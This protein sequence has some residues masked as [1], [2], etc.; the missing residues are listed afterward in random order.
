[1]PFQDLLALKILMSTGVLDSENFLYP[2][3][4]SRPGSSVQGHH[5]GM[6]PGTF[7][8]LTGASGHIM[9]LLNFWQVGDTL[10][11]MFHNLP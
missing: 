1:M 6:A 3:D 11:L 5:G 2:P 7:H 9:G 8:Q 4:A 10:R